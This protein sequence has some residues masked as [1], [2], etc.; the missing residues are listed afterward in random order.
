MR[1]GHESLY[2][3]LSPYGPWAPLFQIRRPRS[4]VGS[5]QISGEDSG[6]ARV[7]PRHARSL[8][9]HWK[10][11]WLEHPLVGSQSVGQTPPQGRD[12]R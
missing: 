2:G 3:P 9:G 1:G 5:H 7:P 4:G 8:P 11:W 6:F 10:E 12:E